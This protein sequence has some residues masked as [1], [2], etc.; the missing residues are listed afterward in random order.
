MAQRIIAEVEEDILGV[1]YELAYDDIDDSVIPTIAKKLED[2]LTEKRESANNK[3]RPYFDFEE[4]KFDAQE[5]EINQEI[6]ADIA[7]NTV[8]ER[9]TASA[10][11]FESIYD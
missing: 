7:L 1:F 9:A 8:N 11:R 6:A 2:K 3:V 5:E 10:E 4:T